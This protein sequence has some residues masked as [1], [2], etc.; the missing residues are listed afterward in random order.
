MIRNN[1][2]EKS[3]VKEYFVE[4]EGG[5]PFSGDGFLS[6]AKNYP[7]SKPRVY[8]DHERI[9]AGRHREIRNKVAGDLLE[10]ARG[11]GFDG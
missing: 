6:R 2:I 3:K 1:F 7:L 5:D 10:G 9:E 11:D 8:H 4:K